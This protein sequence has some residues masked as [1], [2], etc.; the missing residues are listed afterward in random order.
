MC[1]R[2]VKH[3]AT[4]TERGL[5]RRRRDRIIV[6]AAIHMKGAA[7]QGEI[8]EDQPPA[9]LF[10]AC[11]QSVQASGVTREVPILIIHSI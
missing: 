1:K 7:L 2:G 8:E 10:T 9:L 5:R 3:I 4:V 11:S 6:G